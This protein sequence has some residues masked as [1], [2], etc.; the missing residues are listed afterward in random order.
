[1]IIEPQGCAHVR[2]DGILI[3]LGPVDGVGDQVQVGVDGF[4]ACV[5]GNSLTYRVEQ[6]QRL[7]GS[8]SRRLGAG[9]LRHQ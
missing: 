4:L 3:T 6:T 9:R 5:G 1:V 2:N 7:E 8:R